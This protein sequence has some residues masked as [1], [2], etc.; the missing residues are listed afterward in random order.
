MEK[1]VSIPRTG[2]PQLDSF[3][4]EG[5]DEAAKLLVCPDSLW[6]LS[7]DGDDLGHGGEASVPWKNRRRGSE[8]AEE[9]EQVGD[10]G[11]Q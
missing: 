9:G 2:A 5:E 10:G 6:V 3:V 4:E 7:I 8:G 11:E 1:M